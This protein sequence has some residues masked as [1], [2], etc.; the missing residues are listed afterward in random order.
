MNIVTLYQP[1]HPK[2]RHS[3][4]IGNLYHSTEVL[5]PSHSLQ[6]ASNIVLFL[7][8]PLSISLGSGK[9]LGILSSS[10]LKMVVPY[11]SFSEYSDIIYI[12]LYTFYIYIDLLAGCVEFKGLLWGFNIRLGLEG[13][14]DL[15]A[16]MKKYIEIDL[17]YY[18]QLTRKTIL[19]VVLLNYLL[20]TKLPLFVKSALGGSILLFKPPNSS[21]LPSP[22]LSPLKLSDVYWRMVVFILQ[23]RRKFQC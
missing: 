1:N 11:P 20:V 13:S 19:V 17:K 9:L 22:I 10:S 8:K 18:R 14:W 15:P 6:F 3:Y 2:A 12:I 21:I 7:Q 23:Q 16:P 5:E 4:A